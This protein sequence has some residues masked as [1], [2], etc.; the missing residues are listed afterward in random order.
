[1]SA[2]NLNSTH[3]IDVPPSNLTD[4]EGPCDF[5][6]PQKLAHP[7]KKLSCQIAQ[8]RD[9]CQKGR[10]ST[11]SHHAGFQFCTWRAEL[12][13]THERLAYACNSLSSRDL[14]DRQHETR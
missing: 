11:F 1:M 14:R 9:C 13:V 2:S 3:R 10:I 6:K 8:K 5:G 7:T 4:E 12:A